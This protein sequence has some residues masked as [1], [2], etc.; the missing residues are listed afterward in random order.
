MRSRA[1]RLY[2]AYGGGEKSFASVGAACAAAYSWI[3]SRWSRIHN[4]RPCVARI[5][6]LSRGWSVIS[7]MRT[8]GRFALMRTQLFARSIDTNRP[9]SAPT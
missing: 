1:G 7:S 5:I 3:G 4:A 9:V 6:A 8:V 2:I